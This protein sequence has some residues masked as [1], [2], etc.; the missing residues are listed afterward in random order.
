MYKWLSCF[1]PI[2]VALA[3]LQAQ[4]RSDDFLQKLLI[5]KGSPLL[6]NILD[7]PDSFRY[8]LIYTQIDRS[9]HNNP[10]FTNYYLHVDKEQY[11]NPASTVK[12][13]IALLALEKLH[14]LRV[15]M[16]DKYTT[17]LLDSSYSKQTNAWI[18]STSENKLPSVA[19]YVRK[20]FLISDNDA[21]N[22]LYEFDGQQYIN[23][24]LQKKGYRNTVITRSFAPMNEDENRHTSQVRFV[25]GDHLLYTQPAAYSNFKFDFSK[26]I[27]IGNGHLDRNDSLI[28]QPMDFTTH[29][30]F[31]LTDMQQMLQAVLFP[32][33]VSSSKR[34]DLSDDDYRFLYKY[35][36][37]YPSETNFPKYDTTEYFDSYTKFFFFK[38]GKKK[39]P[40]YIRVFNKAGWSYGFLTDAAYVVDFLNGVE[41]MLTATIYTN[42]DGI[43]NDDKYDY[44]TIGYPFFEEVGNI[45][46]NYELQRQKK[47]AP[48]LSKFVMQYD[49]VR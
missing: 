4:S 38:A 23:D 46:Y 31:A 14:K 49:S 10:T 42:S 1:I 27:K 28:M 44:D 40:P 11:F 35:M 13:P 7:K 25:N 33:S 16:V 29:N 30:K 18:D 5:E 39:I 17:M 21:Y 8:Q 26:Q 19:H 3:G 20:I 34:F 48:D 12:L 15:P 24:A 37:Q 2:F 6:L 41:F 22:R 43:L 47:N 32:S 45:I 36:S 9:K